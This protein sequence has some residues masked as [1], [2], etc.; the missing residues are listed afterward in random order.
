[1][2]LA[3]QRRADPVRDSVLF[4]LAVQSGLADP[5]CT[6]GHELVSVELLQCIQNCLL[7]QFR[8]GQNPGL[9]SWRCGTQGDRP[10]VRGKV[11]ALQYA[12]RT[13]GC[14]TLQ[15]ILQF[16]NVARPIVE[17][18]QLHG[19]SADS[20]LNLLAFADAIKEML[21]QQAYVFFAFA[22][23]RQAETYYIQSEEQIAPKG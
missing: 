13:H 12:S 2:R 14:R 3:S 6:G 11:I 21:H 1:R 10:D 17:Q 8:Q 4:Q 15:T 5:Q 22:Q 20:M 16:A 23:W 19:F 9:P 7:F 18:Q